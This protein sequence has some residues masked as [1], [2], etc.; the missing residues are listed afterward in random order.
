MDNKA[1]ILAVEDDFMYQELL[2]A[3]F[4]NYSLEI[5]GTG[6]DG[7]KLAQEIKPDIILLDINLPGIDGY[8]TC[9]ELKE[10]SVTEEIPVL[11]MSQ[12]HELEDRLKA[13]GVGGIDY[14]SKPFD[15]KEVLVKIE[16]HLENFRHQ[17]DL[18]KQLNETYDTVLNMQ[19]EIADIQVIGRFL[20]SNLYCR[21]LDSLFEL[22]FK[23]AQ[24][25][26]VICALQMH[27]KNEKVIR[28]D[29]GSISHL[30]QE[31]LE[32]SGG[33]ERI[34]SFGEDRA[35]FNWDYAN[36]LVRNLGT[37]I[38]LLAILMN[39]LDASIQVIVSEKEL[40]RTVSELEQQNE[41]IKDEISDLFANMS[42]S[43]Q[44]TF[45]S[46]GVISSL[47][48]DEEDKLNDQ[49]ESYHQQVEDRLN[50]LSSNNKQIKRLID[51]MRSPS[52]DSTQE[53]SSDVVDGISFL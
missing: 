35:I 34:F 12:Y 4:S 44:D 20:Q 18:A 26:N 21:D 5:A 30:E 10:N 29:A 39:G 47:D 51:E 3:I 8:K 17:D 42:I 41:L 38:D 24:E 27:D 52:V 28:S 33:M 13:Y 15:K 19:L 32:M 45:L 1:K 16:K 14:I 22:F 23:T 6:E 53:E 43:L 31:I 50:K 7:L 40:L 2:K 37:R 25:L 49:V 11:F 48:P 36:L 9:K 46:L